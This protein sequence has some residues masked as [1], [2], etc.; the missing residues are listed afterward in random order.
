MKPAVSART[1]SSMNTV[2]HVHIGEDATPEPLDHHSAAISQ[3]Y[4]DRLSLQHLLNEH[5]DPAPVYTLLSRIVLASL[6][7]GNGEK[8]PA[9]KGK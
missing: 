8:P 5:F 4:L 9:R 6:D 2:A 3:S 1:L 7:V